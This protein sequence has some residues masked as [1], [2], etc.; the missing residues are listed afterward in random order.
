MTHFQAT[1]RILRYLCGT[2][3]YGILLASGPCDNSFSSYAD[4]DWGRDIGTRRSISGVLHRIGNSSIAWASKLQPTV[5]LSSI[6]AEYRVLTDAAKDIIH[7][8]RLFAEIGL[9]PVTATPLYSDNQ[10]CIRLVDNP[11]IH[12]HTKHIEIQHHFI[13]ETT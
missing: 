7:F 11:V 9:Q 12:A 4:A 2:I 13:C 8:R 3:D 6:E 5:S 1:K 10:S